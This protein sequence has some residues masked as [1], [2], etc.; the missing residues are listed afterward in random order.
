MASPQIEQYVESK[1]PREFRRS[2]ISGTWP[3]FFV[4]EKLAH[5]SSL[6]DIFVSEKLVNFVFINRYDCL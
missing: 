2:T 3:I 6:A 5:F 1:V 4:S